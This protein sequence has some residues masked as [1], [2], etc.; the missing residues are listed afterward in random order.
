M[1]KVSLLFMAILLSVSTLL[2]QDVMQGKKMSDKIPNDPTVMTGKFDNGLTYYI[3][4]NE[5]PDNRAVLQIMIKAGS[6]D[7]EQDQWGLAHFIEHMCFNGT[8]NFPK[9]ELVNYFESIGMQFGA[10]LN[11]STGYDRTL[12]LIELPV[13][14]W[15]TVENGVQILE[16]WLHNVSFDQEELDKERGVILEE[17]RV[18]SGVQGRYSKDLFNYIGEGSIWADRYVIGDTNVILNAPRERFT[19]YYKDWYRPSSSAVVAV[20][21]F[22][23]DKMFKLIESKFADV[24]NRSPEKPR[25][26]ITIPEN[27]EI[28][29]QKF[30]DNEWSSPV[31]FSWY[32]M[33]PKAGKETYGDY[34]YD[35]KR[36]LVSIM[37]SQ[38]FREYTQEEDCPVMQAGGGP[39]G[40]IAN[41]DAF[42]MTGVAKDGKTKEAINFVAGEVFRAKQHGFTEGELERAKKLLMS[43]IEQAYNE[44]DKVNSSAFASEYMA[45]FKEKVYYPGIEVEKKLYDKF[46]PAITVADV[47]KVL[48][49][50]IKTSHTIMSIAA[51]TDVEDLPT[52]EEYKEMYLA[53]SKK[54]YD[55]Y[56]DT[57]VD[58]PLMEKIPEPGSIVKEEKIDE[59]DAVKWTLSNGAEVYLKTTDFKNDQIMMDAFAFGGTS[60]TDLNNLNNAENAASII[61]QSGLGEF[62][63]I[64]LQKILTGKRVRVYPSIGESTVS[65]SGN[66]TNDDLETFFQLVNMYFTAPRVDEKAFNIFKKNSME[67]FEASKNDP[68]KPMRDQMTLTLYDNHPRKQPQKLED[69][70]TLDMNKALEFYKTQ[71][72][73]ADGFKFVFVGSMDEETMKKYVS[74]YIASL[75]KGKVL[76]AKDNDIHYVKGKKEKTVYSGVDPKARIYL[77]RTGEEDYTYENVFKMSALSKLLS[78]RLREV[79]REDEGA[80]YGVGTWVS[81]YKFPYERYMFGVTYTTNPERLDY[82]LDV[83]NNTIEEIRKGN[84][85][86][87]NVS[88]IKTQFTRKRETDLK[89]NR[90]WMNAIYN[91]VLYNQDF[92]VITDF[93]KYVEKIDKDYLTKAAEEYCKDDNNVL[94]I[95]LPEDMKK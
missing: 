38:R 34:Q 73:G 11:A 45:H 20:G 25:R 4:E 61:N 56:E 60:T 43:T 8:K 33:L 26:D 36:S 55:P 31:V 52:K 3:K 82:M 40:F 2:A 48:D 30:T 6:L 16:D 81:P 87:V 41:W 93:D 53:A 74:T 58:K 68:A 51:H 94:V 5:E 66:S 59:I 65:I 79:I 83:T 12:Y 29:V 37:L 78:I 76:A 18:R 21:D 85:D 49:E 22:D 27:K 42:S 7:E 46:V 14:D 47:N 15:G 32:T 1:K 24:K 50:S 44:R 62:T 72:D 35:L 39:G 67:A 71:F 88:K 84:F 77:L 19:S 90:F 86:E 57:A 91:R 13:D 69:I 63:D 54:S 70:E 92:N 75:P 89:K 9:N 80:T 28:R 17:W 95:Q 23:K 64:E 10:D